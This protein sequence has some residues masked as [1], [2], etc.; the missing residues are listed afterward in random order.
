[1]PPAANVLAYAVASAILIVIPGPSVLFTVGRALAYGRRT[2]LATVCGN[3]AGNYLVATCVAFGLGS[4]VQRSAQ[5]LLAVKLAGAL[6]LVWLGVQ[7][8][9]KRAT[10]AEAFSPTAP[11]RSDRRAVREGFLVGVTNPKAFILFGAVLPQFVDR[12][13][14]DVPVQMLL[15][16]LISV[17]IGLV[18]DSTWAVAAGGL[19]AWF[20]RSPRRFALVGGAGGLAM[21]GVG[22]SVAVTGRAN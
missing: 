11:A 2:A 22:V 19:R 10:L 15:L 13:A 6:Y 7:A 8:I 5:V 3:V 20:A 21:I 16:A 12:A 14:G 1:M 9:R 4:L 17:A 18:S